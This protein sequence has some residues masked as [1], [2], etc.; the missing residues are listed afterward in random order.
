MVW[1]RDCKESI[2]EFEEMIEL[3]PKLTN[4][5]EHDDEGGDDAFDDE[6][7]EEEQY[8]EKEIGV[9]KAAVN[10]MKCSKNVLGLVLK[11]CECV[12]EKISEG[13][14][15]EKKV[16]ASDENGNST[17]DED[18]KKQH[19]KDM[20]QW[21]SNLHEL[22]REVGEGVTDFGILLYPPMDISE[23]NEEGY[24][25][26]DAASHHNELVIPYLGT[27]KLGRCLQLQLNR[28]ADCVMYIHD[29]TLSG[30]SKSIQSCMSEEVAELTVKMKKAIQVRGTEVEQSINSTTNSY[31]N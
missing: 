31:K 30:S 12:G 8:S 7:Q 24:L 20:L 4:V 3:G 21:I 19:N 17:Q 6:F 13:S 14:P 15:N 9:A 26:G 5:S 28:L 22:A 29:G 25:M 2:E 27:S 16:P 23:T 11:T 1:V 18:E 10:V